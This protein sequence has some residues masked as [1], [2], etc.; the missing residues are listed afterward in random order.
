MKSSINYCTNPNH[1]HKTYVFL[2]R[3]FLSRF[4]RQLIYIVL[5]TGD[6]DLIEK[7]PNAVRV[8]GVVYVP[9]GA[10]FLSRL[11]HP[12]LRQFA[13]VCFLHRSQWCYWKEDACII[14]TTA[15]P[16]KQH[17]LVNVTSRPLLLYLTITC[18][19]QTTA[20]PLKQHRLYSTGKK[21][22]VSR[23]GREWLIIILFYTA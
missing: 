13:A 5:E 1:W 3:K 9:E 12:Q 10:W 16:L 8:T 20:W 6:T 4:Y 17:R 23:E 2:V 19:I 11:F 15:W 14:Q 21:C 7:V 18:I 22:T